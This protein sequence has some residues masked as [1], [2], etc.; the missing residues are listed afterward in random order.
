[1]NDLILY[2]NEWYEV[3][4]YLKG[5]VVLEDEIGNL[6]HVKDKDIQVPANNSVTYYA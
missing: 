6:F 5:S 2:R 1:M 3:N 4:Q